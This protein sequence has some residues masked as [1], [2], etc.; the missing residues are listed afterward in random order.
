MNST[1][2]LQTVDELYQRV[3]PDL[4]PDL[5]CVLEVLSVVREFSLPLMHRLI[6]YVC[7]NIAG[8]PSQ[9]FLLLMVK[10]LQELDL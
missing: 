5:Q 3:G 9:T 2:K 10:Q 6:Y 4:T 7:S 1:E 8:S